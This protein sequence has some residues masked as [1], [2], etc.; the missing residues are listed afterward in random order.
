[1]NTLRIRFSEVTDDSALV[2]IASHGC[3]VTV[4]GLERSLLSMGLRVTRSRVWVSHLGFCQCL[5]VFDQDQT[6][7]MVRRT[8]AILA[9]LCI[10]LTPQLQAATRGDRKRR[11]EPSRADY[12]T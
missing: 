2:E 3:H 1:M 5:H 12:L 6:E 4:A 7:P 8:A 9:A 10:A 11:R